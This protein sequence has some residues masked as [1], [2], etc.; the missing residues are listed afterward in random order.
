VHPREL[1]FPGGGVCGAVVGPLQ[2]DA[3]AQVVDR[4]AS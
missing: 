1:V 4:G 2:V 3:R